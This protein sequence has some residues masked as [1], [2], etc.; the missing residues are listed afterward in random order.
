MGRMT[1]V[2]FVI[3]IIHVTGIHKCQV[4]FF[5][6]FMYMAASD[7]W[8]LRVVGETA[9]RGE[10]LAGYKKGVENGWKERLV[11]K[12]LYGKFW[13]GV[14]ANRRVFGVVCG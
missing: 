8:M 9:V 13:T 4:M 10:T 14:K 6:T 7:G 3:S 11:E 5:Q 12:M 2:L 1:F